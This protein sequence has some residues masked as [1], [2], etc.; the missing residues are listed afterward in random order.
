[1]RGGIAAPY[2]KKLKEFYLDLEGFEGQNKLMKKFFGSIFVLG[3]LLIVGLVVAAH[4][5]AEPKL[6]DLIEE[7]GSAAIEGSLKVGQVHI[8]FWPPISVSLENLTGVTTKKPTFNLNIPKINISLDLSEIVQARVVAKVKVTK[9]VLALTIPK[10]TTPESATAKAGTTSGGRFVPGQGGIALGLNLILDQAQINVKKADQDYSLSKLNVDFLAPSLTAPWNLKITTEAQGIPVELKSLF[11]FDGDIFV[12]QKT[13]VNLSGIKVDLVGKSVLS[14]EDH[15]WDAKIDVPEL[16][17]LIIPPQLE[18][19]LKSWAGLLQGQI[20]AEHVKGTPWR[21]L[22]QIQAKNVETEVD[23]KSSGNQVQ[24]VISTDANVDFSYQDTLTFNKL[25]AAVDLSKT[26]IT[27]SQ[28]S[29]PSGVVLKGS[30]VASGNQNEIN[31]SQSGLQ[32]GPLSLSATGKV[33]SLPGGISDLKLSMPS[34][35]LSGLEKLF[36][37][38]ASTPLTGKLEV[39]GTVRGDLKNPKTLALNINPLTLESVRGAVNWTSPDKTKSVHGPLTANGKVILVAQ[40]QNVSS[41]LVNLQTDLSDLDISMSTQL[42]KRPHVPLRLNLKAQQKGQALQITQGD[43]TT[44]AGVFNLKGNIQDP[45]SPKLNL[46]LVM[47]KLD[48]N[49]LS[50]LVPTLEPWKLGGTAQGKISL[51][52]L[53]DLTLGIEKSPLTLVG[54]VSANIPKFNYAAQKAAAVAP[55]PT[56]NETGK[57]VA[58]APQS[59][60]PHWPIMQ[61]M[62]FQARV[63]LQNVDYNNLQISGVDLNLNINHGALTGIVSVQKI[64]GGFISADKIQMAL[65]TPLA[66]LATQVT[67][68]NLDIAE[69]LAYGAPKWKDAAKGMASGLIDMHVASHESKDFIGETSAAGHLQIKNGFLSTVSFDQ[70]LNEKLSSIPGLGSKKVV[71]TKGTAMEVST[72]FDF[73]HSILNIKTLDAVTPEKNEL[74]VAGIIKVDQSLDLKGKVWLGPSTLSGD[75]VKCNADSS[76]RMV[77]P[78]HVSGT[79][80]KPEYNL[81]EGTAQQ[82][83]AQMASCQANKLKSQFQDQIQNRVQDEAKKS[84]QNLFGH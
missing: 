45:R 27:S 73:N 66:P 71:N 36:P 28:F 75:I 6:K 20:H 14:T 78:V 58:T 35:N 31:I 67:I 43:L 47:P 42:Q 3:I 46:T 24:G 25:Q 44:S 64:F 50:K 52:G 15:K 82:L 84:L 4:F 21:A 18:K 81:V 38:L 32:L 72:I 7:K 65:L 13:D 9:P 10:T 34:T 80:T 41:A 51:V 17:S 26:T 68:R 83:I 59:I 22:G 53:Y 19:N 37:A 79:A 1:V 69:A 11:T 8:V 49:M 60:L 33:N 12:S 40:G 55:A 39:Q 74:N 2:H 56:P 29:K 54:N 5:L 48:L 76:G 77:I 70:Y 61:T 63:K 23:V 62:K 16:K 30:V 57:P